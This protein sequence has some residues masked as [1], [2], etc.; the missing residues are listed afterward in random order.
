MDAVGKGSIKF[1][2]CVDG[3]EWVPCTMENVLHVPKARRNLLSVIT[4]TEKWLIF[5]STKNG[6]EFFQDGIV[7]ARGV[8][9]GRLYKILM[10]EQEPEKRVSERLTS[11]HCR[12][13]MSG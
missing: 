9:D 2:A 1:E 13:G 10:R 7:K 5:V 11:T 8:C 4:A 3:N 6:C 12:F